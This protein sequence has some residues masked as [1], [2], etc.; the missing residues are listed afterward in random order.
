MSTGVPLPLAK[1]DAANT[2]PWPVF[3]YVCPV[4]VE[5]GDIGML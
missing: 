5:L 1:S 2:N 3:V 4:L